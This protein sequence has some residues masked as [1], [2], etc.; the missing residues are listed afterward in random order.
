MASAS[1]SHW[2]SCW[3]GEAGC[4]KE[5]CKEQWKCHVSRAFTDGRLEQ[6]LCWEQWRAEQVHR[7]RPQPLWTWG[8]RMPSD[9]EM[10]NLLP[11]PLLAS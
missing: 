6:G 2:V 5:S 9:G 7:Q 11:I 1:P 10:L 4:R 3:M 8:R